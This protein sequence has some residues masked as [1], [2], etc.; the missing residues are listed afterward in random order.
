M[1]IS[2]KIRII[3]FVCI[4]LSGRVIAQLHVEQKIAVASKTPISLLGVYHFGNPNQDLFNVK[5]DNIL[6]EKRQKE[7]ES[8][9]K[10]L[11]RFKPTHIA[12]EFNK[13]DSALDKRYQEYLKGKYQLGPGEHEQIGFRLARLLGHQ[14]IYPVDES[15]I[16]LNFEPGELAAEFSTL[17]QQLSETGNKV[18]GQINKWV[19]EKSIG[20]VLSQLNTSELDKLNI[21]LYYRFLLPI[22]KGNA[23]PGLEAVTSWYKRNLYIL[24]HIKE[25]VDTDKS[26]KR[27]LVIFG[28]GHTAMLKQFLQYS[29]E[30]EL[31]DIQQFLPKE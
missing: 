1:K 30:F 18:V 6:S 14:H 20:A 16:Q 25:L 2:Q 17:L 24:K 11:A 19:Q 8:L 5:S 15:S 27:V 13:N 3:Y 22:G 28:Q 31:V 4:L 12:L 23:Q 10:E 9:V 26:E 21:D 29:T 7:L